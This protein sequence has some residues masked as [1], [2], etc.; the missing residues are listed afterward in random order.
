MEIKVLGSGC[1]KCG[2]LMKVTQEI[3][4]EENLDANVEKIEDI[5]K[6][7]SYGVMASPGLVVDEEVKFAGRLPSKKEIKKMLLD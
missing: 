2:K 5:K 6:I 7:M 1:S 4:K 3:V